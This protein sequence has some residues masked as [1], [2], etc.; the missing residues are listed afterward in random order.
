LRPVVPRWSHFPPG[1]DLECPGVAF[2]DVRV[3]APDPHDF[4]ADGDGDGD[5]DGAA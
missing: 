3:L 4:D 2:I 1:G 5:G